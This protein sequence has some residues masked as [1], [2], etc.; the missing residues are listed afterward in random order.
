MILDDLVAATTIRMRREQALVPLTAMKMQAEA[1]PK[2]DLET[3]RAAL[4]RGADQPL[5][6]IAEVKKASPSKG[7]IAKDFNPVAT[8]KE[9]A[10]A[11]V[12]AISVLTEPDYFQGDIDF[13]KQIA[14]QVKLPLLRKDFTIDPYMIYQARAAGAS[15]ILLIVAILDDQQLHDYLQLAHSLGLEA[16]VE[17]H[18][19]AEVARA[20]AA[21]AQIIGVNNRDLRT[22]TVD[23]NNSVR[24][25][26]AVPADRIFIAESGVHTAA[27]AKVL[28]DAGADTILVGEAFMRADN[29]KALLAELV[30]R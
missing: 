4:R 2:P 27:D 1:A 6:V 21:G 24:L 15:L 28:A 22:F 16:I 25:R 5:N 23:L 29:K 7:L 10:A 20:L 13:L 18:S 3:T 14:A 19:E 30:G 26:K 9:Y 12:N 17:A 8:G 11:G